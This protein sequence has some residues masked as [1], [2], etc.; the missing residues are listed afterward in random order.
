MRFGTNRIQIIQ[1]VEKSSSI[2]TL[3]VIN[4]FHLLLDT[5][6]IQMSVQQQEINFR[7]VSFLNI[8][9]LEKFVDKFDDLK[10]LVMKLGD[11][12]NHV[13]NKFSVFDNIWRQSCTL[14]VVHIVKVLIWHKQ[15]NCV[16]SS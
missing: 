15:L 13:I 5:N 7:L 6:H 11:V 16:F 3:F 10:K 14:C 9:Q 1:V 4:T 12:L 8:I 2:T